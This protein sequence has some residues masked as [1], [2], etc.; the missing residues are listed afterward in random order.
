[1]SPNQDDEVAGGPV[2]S[3]PSKPPKKPSSRKKGDVVVAEGVALCCIGGIGIV[4]EGT[5][6]KPEMF[7]EGQKTIDDLVEKGKLV[8]Q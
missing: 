8:N 3:T 5:V 7:A 1:M 2:A 6:V 4:G